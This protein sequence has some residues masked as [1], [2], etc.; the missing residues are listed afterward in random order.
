MTY[1]KKNNRKIYILISLALIK[2]SSIILPYNLMII[3]FNFILF[4]NSFD[5]L[6]ENNFLFFKKI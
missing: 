6:D 1:I 5:L 2:V 3:F 4:W